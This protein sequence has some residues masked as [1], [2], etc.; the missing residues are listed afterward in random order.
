[1][2]NFNII[3]LSF[4]SVNIHQVNAYKVGIMFSIKGM[5]R[6][7]LYKKSGDL[8]YTSRTSITTGRVP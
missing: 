7:M 4:K 6:A 1:M 8:L 2:L 3:N 5:S